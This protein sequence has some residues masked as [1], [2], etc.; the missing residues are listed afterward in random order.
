[1]DRLRNETQPLVKDPLNEEADIRTEMGHRK[2]HQEVR[3]N[4]P[5]NRTIYRWKIGQHRRS[6]A[7]T[8]TVR[9]RFRQKT[10]EIEAFRALEIEEAKWCKDHIPRKGSDINDIT[11]ERISL[12]D[13]MELWWGRQDLLWACHTLRKKDRINIDGSFWLHQSGAI[14]ATFTSDWYLRKGESRDKMGEWLKKTTVRSQDQRRMLQANIHSFPSHYLR[15][16]ITKGKE[17]NRCD[18]CRTLWI[19]EGRFNTEDDL[20]IQTLGHIQHQC[21]ALSE[22]HTLAHHRCWRIIHAELGRLASSDRLWNKRPDGFPIG[23]KCPPKRRRENL[24]FWKLK[25]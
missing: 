14:S 7:W 3:W 1:M 19:V 6:T 18:L 15:H 21:E 16:K 11:E 12:L 22:I 4:N 20:P 25:S 17:S 8:N 24:S 9:S 5:T 13:N 2:E 10:G 23:L